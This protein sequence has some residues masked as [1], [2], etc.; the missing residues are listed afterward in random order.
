MAYIKKQRQSKFEDEVKDEEDGDNSVLN[1]SN[2]YLI[3]PSIL[4]CTKKKMHKMSIRKQPTESLRKLKWLPEDS[5][6]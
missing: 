4:S 6:D 1:R 5:N 2:N 3:N